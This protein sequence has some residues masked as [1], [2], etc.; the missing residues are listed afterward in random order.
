MDILNYDDHNILLNGQPYPLNSIRPRYPIVA[1]DNTAALYFPWWHSNALWSGDVTRLLNGRTSAPFAGITDFRAFCN[2]HFYTTSGADALPAGNGNYTA[3]GT[4]AATVYSIPHGLP[5]IPGYA[6]IVARNADT[7]TLLEGGWYLAYDA[8]NITL[9]LLVPTAG[10]PLINI[11]WIAFA[12]PAVLSRTITIDASLCGGAD[13]TDMPVLVSLHHA[14]LRTRANGGHVAGDAGHDI[15]FYADAAET[16]LLSWEIEE[17]DGSTG[18]LIAW[19][20]VPTVSSTTDTV[21]YMQYGN[22]AITTF[23]G[24]STGAAWSNG[25]TMVQHLPDGV[26]LSATDSSGN[27]NDGVITGATATAGVIDGG[28]SFDGTSSQIECGYTSVPSG[29][30]PFT[31]AAWLYMPVAPPAD[32]VWPVVAWGAQATNDGHGIMVHDT[33]GTTSLVFL[34]WNNDL[35]YTWT[36]AANTWYKIVTVYDGTTA[37]LYLNGLLVASDTRTIS[38]T[39]GSVD[40]G[41]Y[42]GGV[43]TYYSPITVDEVTIS[44]A[45]RTADWILT[46]YNNQSAPGNIGTPG[47]LTI[48]DEY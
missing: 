37:Y 47:F 36:P 4:T 29:S 22:A 40:I 18:T 1:G 24:G 21:F 43:V 20:K 32:V 11:D 16:T 25:Y 19:V 30:D 13:S 26:T 9:T 17:Y 45:T 2:A 5:Y 42:T 23:R 34:L 46:E 41:W 28:A 8:V 6:D 44:T 39:P 12:V 14:T 15:L 7:A 38:T 10:T 27:S 31:V 33:A 48:G 35:N 3:T